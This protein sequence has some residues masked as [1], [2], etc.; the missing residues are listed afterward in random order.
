MPHYNNKIE[1]D[2]NLDI[3]R[4]CALIYI[5]G[6]I[7]I[8]G[9]WVDF[10]VYNI[11][12]LM[13]IVMPILFYISGA[14]YA[15]SGKKSYVQYIKNRIKRIIIPLL[16]YLTIYTTYNT[17]KGELLPQQLP[18]TILKY[19]YN[20][21]FAGDIKELD[22]LWYIQPYIIIALLLP[23]LYYVSQHI[24]RWGTYTLLLLN[25][26]GIYFFPG[27]IPCYIV[28]TYAGLYYKRDKPYNS[29]VVLA[30]FVAAIILWVAQGNTWNI[31]INKFP[32]TLMYLSYTSCMLIILNRPLKW[33][34]QQ[35]T[36]MP[37]LRYIINHYAQHSYSIYLYHF[38]VMR[39]VHTAYFVICLKLFDNHPL[40][41][42]P[43]C[44]LTVIAIT[45]L[46]VL[47][48]LSMIVDHIN[49]AVERC[50]SAIWHKTTSLCQRIINNDE[51][52][53]SKQG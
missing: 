27:Y 30:I 39:I 9:Y 15:L 23:L 36:R 4:G 29:I 2:N 35:A 12:S 45:T 14:S 41:M 42:H 20:I 16:V 47:I 5:V 51:D 25:L 33:L 50:V 21:I 3:Y 7:H 32:P 1:R 24:N 46:L 19:A 37:I 38:N 52:K 28:A 44:S 8:I 22:P 10:N 17:I 31:Q 26:A 48:P 11:L 40:L 53:K 43:A 18:G 34:C 6:I 49:N 13:L